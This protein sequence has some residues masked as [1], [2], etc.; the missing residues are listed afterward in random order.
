MSEIRARTH[1]V[2]ASAMFMYSG[3]T[4]IVGREILTKFDNLSKRLLYICIKM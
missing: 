4:V 1:G 3:V 2:I